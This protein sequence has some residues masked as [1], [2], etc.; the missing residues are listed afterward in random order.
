M[1]PEFVDNRN[2]NTLV[3]AL[4]GHIAWLKDTYANPVELSIATG[5]FNPEGFYLVAEELKSLRNIR[6]LLGAEPVPPPAMPIRKPGDPRGEEYDA[7]MVSRSLRL[8]EEGLVRDRNLLGFT[9]EQDESARCLIEFLKEGNIEVRRYTRSFLHG[10]AF[11]FSDD[12][13][14]I[15]GS[16]NFT[17]AG[18]TSNLELNLGR[19]DPTPV[20]QVKQWFDDLWESD[21]AE[22][23]DLAALYEARFQMYD[24]Y[25]IYLRVLWE[26]YG[27][28]LEEE[29]EDTSPIRLTTFQ[30][31]G[32]Q[33]ARRILEK[34]HGVIIADGVG[35]G[36]SFI[37][38][39][40]LRETVQDRR[41][42]ALLI[43][44]AA[45]RDG[46]WQRF[47]D[48]FQLYVEKISYEQLALE[49][50]LGGDHS[51]LLQDV[52]QY[53][54]I[55]IDEAQAFRTPGTNRASSLRRL[56]QGSP[57]KDLVMLSAT[58]VNNSLWDL[59]YL[60]QYFVK[61]DAVFSDRGVPSLRDR[62]KEAVNEDP[63]ELRPDILF[64]I[65]D[66]TTVRRTRHFVQKYYSRDRI[67]GPDGTEVTI[68]F[69]EP[70]IHKVEYQLD[71]V[72]PGFFDEFANALAPEQGEPELS[73]A[74]YFPSQFLKSGQAEH[75][76]IAL[77]GLLRSAML[78]RFESS[79]YA[80]VRTINRMV[81]QHRAFLEALER[82]YVVTAGILEEW[83]EVDTDEELDNLLA[84]SDSN[85]A[86]LYDGEQ[87]EETVRKDLII[88]E[89][90]LERT[91]EIE[92]DT[93][94]K[95]QELIDEL[96]HILE[97]ANADGRTEE[98]RRDNRKVIIFSYYTDT[99]NWIENYLLDQVDNDPRLAFYRDRIASVSSEDSRRGIA[100]DAAIT[101]FAP[102]ST[103][104]PPHQAE[105]LF[106]IL[107]TTDVLAEGQNLQQCRN[108]INYD[109]PWNPMRLVQ[110][111]GR[112]DRIGSKHEDIYIRCFFPD[113][114]LDE[115][116]QLEERI[117]R[118]LAQ[119]A[120]S[121]GVESEVIPQGAT[122]DLVFADTYE[123]ILAIQAE[124][125][126]LLLRAGEELN[127]YS[128]EEYRQEL[129]Q[130]LMDRKWDIENL[131]WGSG[132]GLYGNGEP[133]HFFCARVGDRVYLRFVPMNEDVSVITD[134][135]GC[136]RQITCTRETERVLSE[137]MKEAAYSAW[138]K[139]R[140]SIYQDWIFETDPVNLQP[141]IRP[142][143]RQM[144]EHIRK[145]TPQGIVQSDLNR[146]LESLE[147][148][149]G[150]RYE[151]ELRK[152]FSS[153]ETSEI[154]KSKQIINQLR[155][156]GLEPYEP[157]KPLP[158]I[159][160]DE[161]RLICWMAVGG[162]N[163]IEEG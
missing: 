95:L 27:S 4:K 120:A 15:A 8:L 86:S 151:N 57:P 134:T 77:V 139:A 121:V 91:R 147:A 36:K 49:Q 102:V 100:R 137:Y 111:N 26:L 31:D 113:I 51:Y 162:G 33:R 68:Q 110:R 19:Y 136:L 117:R 37:G 149:W 127:A 13:G 133:G 38:G 79:A 75:N 116:L 45:L 138:E 76:E 153:E 6:L 47:T 97:Q 21:F 132:S 59:Y 112:I 32:I 22:P 10:K 144:A 88:L 71:E 159:D 142:L 83:S 85:P 28:E 145:H 50:Q 82:G 29:Q 52:N 129:R 119:A 101:G 90:F 103:E 58:P 73:L 123:Q 122:S 154:E 7:R 98:E 41:Q 2:G 11:V 34:Y 5:Y 55:V 63:Y 80:F 143:F 125:P 42:R 89:N 130:G 17:A 104:A 40:L 46:T 16:S 94:P 60:L 12:E 152:I 155:E 61:H 64:D 107:I 126:D 109:L 92:S 74:R 39:E 141:Y 14:V 93:D 54:L 66:A 161:I 9:Y 35:L 3:R 72:L 146:I 131:P 84:S 70:H 135:L 18:L 160:E 48:R 53:S 62:F 23:Y 30:N 78:K 114:H 43:S 99:V 118:K 87:L 1:K 148:P 56:L 65:L 24:P 106:D 115:L 124:D 128:G 67:P 150:R 140:E 96:V 158:L 20:R 69:P 105:N 157:P 44:P 81:E 156:L 108:I 25:L 163:H